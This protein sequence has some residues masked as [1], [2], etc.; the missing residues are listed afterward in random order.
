MFFQL[1]K[2]GMILGR[3]KG[4]MEFGSRALEIDQLLQIKFIRNYKKINEKSKS[5]ILD[6]FAPSVLD[7]FSKKYFNIKKM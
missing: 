3:C 7:K 2:K 1:L 4:K 6:A 5:E